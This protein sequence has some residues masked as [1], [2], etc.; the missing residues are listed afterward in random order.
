MHTFVAVAM[1]SIAF[2]LIITG[3]AFLSVPLAFIVAGLLII[4]LFLVTMGGIAKD[5][6]TH[7]PHIVEPT[8]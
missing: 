3:V 1:L 2:A 8:E 4:V 6:A 7:E 5:S